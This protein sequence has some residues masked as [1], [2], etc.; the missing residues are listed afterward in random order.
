MKSLFTHALLFLALVVLVACGGGGT[1]TPQVNVSS[2]E[3][4]PKAV[5]FTAAG[6]RKT[7]TARVLGANNQ[8]LELKVKWTSANP[9]V[10][11][12]DTGE[13]QTTTDVGSSVISAEANGVT[14]Q[15]IV[16]IAEPVA[17]ARLISDSQ[18]LSEPEPV[19]SDEP[20]LVG[21]QLKV[22]LAPIPDIVPGT[23]LL[24]SEAKAVAGKVISVAPNGEQ[25]DVVFE[26]LPIKMMFRK[27]DIS[28]EI[29]GTAMNEQTVRATAQPVPTLSGQASPNE[30]K[31]G[32]FTCTTSSSFSFLSGNL[33]TKIV[34]PFRL[35][36]ALTEDEILFK[37]V[38]PLNSTVSGTL[39][40]GANLSFSTTCKQ[41][42]GRIVLPVGGALAYLAGF[43]LPYGPKFEL[44]ASLQSPQ[45]ELGLEVKNSLEVTAGVR[46]TSSEGW[47][48]LFDLKSSNDIK[49]KFNFPTSV[50][51]FRLEGSVF[52]GA[53]LGFD[54]GSYALQQISLAKPLSLLEGSA[55]LKAEVKFGGVQ[56]QMDD[57]GYASKYELKAAV[58]I[59]L[60]KSTA[61]AVKAALK[62][63]TVDEEHPEGVGGV[64][65]KTNVSLETPLTRSPFGSASVDKN[66]AKQEEKVKFTINLD[67]K[68][69][70]L[71]PLPLTA[72]YNVSQVIIY[73][74]LEGGEAEEIK[75]LSASEGQKNFEWEWT[76]GQPDVGE[77]RFWVFVLPKVLFEN[78]ALEIKDDSMLKVKVSCFPLGNL[79]ASAQTT[80]L[81]PQQ[82]CEDKWLGTSSSTID[83][84]NPTYE[85]SADVTWT[86]EP[87]LS[88]PVDGEYV[89]KPEGTVSFTSLYGCTISPSSY[90]I[91]NENGGELRIDYS[92]DP[93]SYSGFGTTLWS[94]TYSCPDF[95]SFTAGAGGAWFLAQ[96]TLEENGNTIQG[97]QTNS[98]QT[99][100]FNFTRP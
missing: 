2:I 82:T 38:G 58:E 86:Y 7:L 61:D 60:G 97:T 90:T 94:A 79:T 78:F 93:P 9:A 70:F 91:T 48:D 36:Y 20:V 33:S 16:V 56:T 88:S 21:S 35:S 15:I 45:V 50:K 32:P 52:A 92:T 51:N 28:G 83:D 46:W 80:G 18:I 41:E 39:T 30:F 42:S 81:S 25:L 17:G 66:V 29:T 59:G 96:G 99:F 72:L 40:I 98:G 44:K 85:I 54:L 57:S 100:T 14:A 47:V 12:S 3:I 87:A 89:Y 63:L 13:L 95:G 1:G 77:N 34:F 5:L 65:L 67:E 71:R 8:P 74:S 11:V 84:F 24:A 73:R 75:T 68:D 43:Q 62:K 23:V 49:G 53:Y 6:E 22:K 4:S 27:F 64:S 55:G 37:A 69:A 76:P 10:T 26:A 19:V 31:L